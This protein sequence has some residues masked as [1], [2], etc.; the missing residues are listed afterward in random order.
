MRVA[1]ACTP[2][3]LDCTQRRA[4]V[5]QITPRNVIEIT[6]WAKWPNGARNLHPR[7]IY[8][9]DSQLDHAHVSGSDVGIRSRDLDVICRRFQRAK[10]SGPAPGSFDRS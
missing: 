10:I 9:T 1:N 5:L 8:A 4:H 3:Q 6:N 2:S 7:A